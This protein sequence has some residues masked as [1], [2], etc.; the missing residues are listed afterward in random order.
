M[1]WKEYSNL[2][3]KH[4]Y[5]SPS[6][7]AWLNYDENK[8]IDVYKNY[9]AKEHGTRLHAFACE[10]ISLGLRSYMDDKTINRYIND[11]ITYKM[12]PEQV[13]YYSDKCFGT[14]DA[15]SFEEEKLR[16][17]DL[18]TGKTKASFKQLEIYAA[19]FC[20]DYEIDPL[21]ISFEL[22]IYQNDSIRFEDPEPDHILYVMNRIIDSDK[23]LDDYWEDNND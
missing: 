1:K 13:L 2:K 5:L 19:L 16:V 14:A 23:I 20:L 3:E 10:A 9:L 18:K 22:R 17:F 6:K 21:T 7:Y 8:Q 15:I 12:R 4:A 11:C